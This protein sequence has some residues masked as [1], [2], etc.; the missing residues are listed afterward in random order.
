[1][2]DLITLE[3][4]QTQNETNSNSYTSSAREA[5]YAGIVV[6]YNRGKFRLKVELKK[7]KT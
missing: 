2:L 5:I 1:M 3:W 6:E 7:K 4:E